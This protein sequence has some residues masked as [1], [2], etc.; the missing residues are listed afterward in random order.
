MKK[1]SVIFGT[2]PEA[3]KMATLVLQLKLHTADVQTGVENV[4]TL[5]TDS[6]AYA[7]TANAVNPY[8]DGEPC[9]QIRVAMEQC[10]PCHRKRT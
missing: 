8:G 1:I 2:C 4:S 5:L 10:L 6:A 9:E 7:A 3:I